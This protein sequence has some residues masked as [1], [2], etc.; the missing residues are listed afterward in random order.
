MK[1]SEALGIIVS[2]L[3]IDGAAGLRNLA[4]AYC[5]VATEPLEMS[6][7][8]VIV[9]IE[10]TIYCNLN[11]L[12]CVN[13][14]SARKKRHM[15]LDEFKRIVDSL[16]FVK[17]ISM[18]GAGEPLMNPDL[19]SMIRYAKSR[20][21]AIGFATNGT[22]LNDT[23]CRRIVSSG[24]DWIN[25]SVDSADS[26]TYGRIRKGADLKILI[27]NMKRLIELVG[28]KAK[29][30]ISIWFVMMEDNLKELRGV[31]KLA[32]EVGIKKVSAQ[33]A[34]SWSDERLKV[35]MAG[36]ESLSF[37]S[38]VRETLKEAR[39][40]ATKERIEFDYVNVPDETLNRACKWPW[41]SCYI[42]VE[43]FITPCCLQGSDPGIIN[44]GNI[45]EKDFKTIWNSSAYKEFRKALK[46]K[47]PPRICVDCTSYF[48]KVKI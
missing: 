39:S 2:S 23:N 30:E 4:L 35:A 27:E 43:G 41:R 15:T 40:L 31:I 47:G 1:L 45:Y 48:G 12:M 38:A 28:K 6:S 7:F 5:N 11:C 37:R 46:Y 13:P 22:L 10:P 29:P 33:L 19:F 26:Q 18:V 16:P 32:K 21:I 20:R 9:Q 36:K 17:K 24:A 14:I 34:H 25:I 8:P 3:R 44:F 42:T